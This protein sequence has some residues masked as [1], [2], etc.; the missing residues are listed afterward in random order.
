MLSLNHHQS[1]GVLEVVVEPVLE[2]MDVALPKLLVCVG[3]SSQRTCWTVCR[4]ERI[5]M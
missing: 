3:Q 1:Q 4:M 5:Y 2:A